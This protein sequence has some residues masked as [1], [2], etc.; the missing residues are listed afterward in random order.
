MGGGE[1]ETSGQIRQRVHR[2]VEVQRERFKGSP[3][4]RNARIP[5]AMIREFCPL[6]AEAEKAFRTAKEKLALS[7]RAF[8]GVLRTARTIADLDGNDRI[9]TP[10]I[11][12]AVQHRRSGEDPYDILAEDG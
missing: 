4:R 7:G 12:E 8:H 6:T 11:L 1:E 5:A 9:H 3:I 2:A 10:H